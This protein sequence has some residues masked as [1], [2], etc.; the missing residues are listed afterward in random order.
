LHHS[1]G[2]YTFPTSRGAAGKNTVAEI[3]FHVSFVVKKDAEYVG[4]G[5][6][7][8]N[9]LGK[10]VDLRQGEANERREFK[11]PEPLP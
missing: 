10:G 11:F 4:A 9:L 3:V 6:R 1:R 8:I 7:R 2:R 5:N